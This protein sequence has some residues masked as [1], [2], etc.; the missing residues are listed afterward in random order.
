[1]DLFLANGVQLILM[2]WYVCAC[3][4]LCRIWLYSEIYSIF[5]KWQTVR[6]SIKP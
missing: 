5:N 3:F 4:D 1:V 6:R 2:L